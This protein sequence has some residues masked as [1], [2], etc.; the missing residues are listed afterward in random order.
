MKNQTESRILK[1]ILENIQE[2]KKL[3]LLLSCLVVFTTT[4]LLI[5]PAFTLD[6][7]EAAEQGGIDVPAVETEAEEVSGEDAGHTSSEAEAATEAK[8]E[9]NTMTKDEAENEAESK[10]DAP[11]QSAAQ[12]DPL[13][14]EGDGFT[15]AVED[16]KSVLPDNTEVVASELLE[17]P[18]EGTKAE[19]KEAEEAY[20][21]YYDLAQETVKGEDGADD[22][23]TIS[24]VKFYDISLQAAG[25][26]VQPDKPVN[27]TISY[28]KN[29]QK[30]L[31]VEEKKNI[32]IIHFAEDKETGEITAE[33]LKDDSVD[34]SL[35]QKKMEET[36]FEAESFSVYGSMAM[37]TALP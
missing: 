2:Q 37:S 12:G 13:T 30:E 9:D 10:T 31:T 3:I 11:S 18:A 5:L 23:R 16:K 34:V 8:T 35:R 14:F 27:V 21:K 4:Y 1:N 20:R 26:D 28:D 33:I 29:Q 6:K 7:E 36:T 24:F 15:V 32:R 19:R 25:E 17:K 22:A